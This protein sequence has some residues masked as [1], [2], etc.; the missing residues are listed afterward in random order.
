MTSPKRFTLLPTA[1]EPHQP[2]VWDNGD[3]SFTVYPHLTPENVAVNYELANAQDCK[4]LLVTPADAGANCVSGIRF[5]GFDG[6]AG[7]NRYAAG[8][9]V[10]ALE[11]AISLARWLDC[12]AYGKDWPWAQW[13]PEGHE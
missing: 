13:E 12:A 7:I 11:A 8:E 2:G 3:G 4:R 1:I 6:Q 5:L 9:I 10:R